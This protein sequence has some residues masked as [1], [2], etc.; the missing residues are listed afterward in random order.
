MYQYIIDKVYEGKTIK[1]YL[2]SFYLSSNKINRIINE[3][4]FLINGVIVDKNTKLKYN[5]ILMITD[6]VFN[7]KKVEPIYKEIEIL[8]EDEHLLVVNK[9]K[10]LI[11]H[12]DKDEA[13]LDRII[14]GLMMKRGLDP[15]PRHIYRLDRD[16]TG[17]MVYAL[18]PLTLS[19]LS[20]KVFT[21]ELEKIYTT[22]I[23]GKVEQNQGTIDQP[24][25][26]HRHINGMMTVAKNGKPSITH[27]NVK[28][29]VANRS[30]LEVKLE[31]GRT[32][33]IRV[34]M[35]NSLFPVVGDK[36]YGSKVNCDLMLQASSLTLVHPVNKKR[37]TIKVSHQISL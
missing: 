33:Q 19:Y 4:G 29:V 24:I 28:K 8:Y 32:H 27:Y 2:E 22:I 15:I 10:N 37:L 6:K 35:S 12:S 26:T 7:E 16:T 25:S 17:C 23:E 9:D 14:A 36:M 11:I 20:N 18:D 5:D 21:K 13:T 30:L 1:E 3:K 34:H 31:T